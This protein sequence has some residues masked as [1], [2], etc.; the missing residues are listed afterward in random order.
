M[1]RGLVDI[2]RTIQT[3]HCACACR[4]SKQTRLS[5][6]VYS[7]PVTPVTS[8]AVIAVVHTSD[9]DKAVSYCPLGGRYFPSADFSSSSFCRRNISDTGETWTSQNGHLYYI[10]VPR[11]N[12]ELS[13]WFLFDYLAQSPQYYLPS[14]ANYWE[15]L[16]RI[17]CKQLTRKPCWRHL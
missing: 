11:Q 8:A 1:L 9:K 3:V 10:T 17:L 2:E 7:W 4:R 15:L 12:T 13:T 14:D 6:R 16:S 5:V